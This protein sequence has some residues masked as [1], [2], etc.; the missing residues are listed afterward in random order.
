MVGIFYEPVADIINNVQGRHGFRFPPFMNAGAKATQAS[1]HVN[2]ALLGQI[3]EALSSLDELHLAGCKWV[4]HV[5][6]VNALRHNKNGIKSLTI[7][8]NSYL[9]VRHYASSFTRNEP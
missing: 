4:I 6:L 1:T 2:D 9:L 5:G 7:D 3:S 8:D